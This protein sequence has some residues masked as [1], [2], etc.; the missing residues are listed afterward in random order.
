[1]ERVADVM[2]GTPYPFGSELF[3]D[4]TGHDQVYAMMRRFGRREKMLN[5]LPII[6][7]LR[8]GAQPVWFWYGNEKRG[9]V[10]CWYAQTQNSRCLLSGYEETGD[11]EMLAWG[12]GGLTSFLTTVQSNGSARGWFL[13]WP[14]RMGFD[15]RSLDTDLGLYGYLLAAKA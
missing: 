11:D 9:N 3:V 1:M 14:D 15:L 10:C 12:Y 6:K 8:A 5:A 4:Q 13:W 7:A 2:E